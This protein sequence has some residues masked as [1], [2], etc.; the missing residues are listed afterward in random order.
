MPIN[1][2]K[3]LAK[4]LKQHGKPIGVKSATLIVTTPG[5]RT[6][7]AGGTNPTSTSY[8][9]KAFIETG[10][11]SHVSGSAANAAT[12]SR[13]TDRTISI[14][15]GSLPAGVIPVAGHQVAIADIDGVSK[16]FRILGDVGVQSGG[17]G[18]Q[19]DGVGAVHRM[20]CRL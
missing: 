9:C 16:T 15:G 4:A 18:V 20:Q 19:V 14:L 17:V 6:T 1:L 3:T 5:T 11:S 7:A 13:Q 2:A 10:N 12:T 8:P